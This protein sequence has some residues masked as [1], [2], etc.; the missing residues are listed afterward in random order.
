MGLSAGTKLG[1]YEII[2]RLGAGGMGEVFRAWDARLDR[3]VALKVIHPE[4]AADAD[5]LARFEQ[6]AKAA[7]RLD[8][9]NILV[10][11]DVGAHEG[12]PY[13]VSELLEGASLRERLGAPLSTK[14]A[15]DIALQIA[16]GLAAAHEK[17]I[18]HRDLKPE[19][20]FVLKDG[21]TKILDFGVAKLTQRTSDGAT[22]TEATTAAATEPG[23]V[24]GTIGYMSPEQVQGRPLE[25]RSDLFSLGVV[26]YEMLAGKRPF[27]GRTAP[28]TLTAILREEPPDLAEANQ[29]IPPPL[30]RIVR[31]CLEKDPARRFQAAR[32]LVFDLEALAGL[33]DARPPAP[34]SA[35]GVFLHRRRAAVAGAAFV[36]VLAVSGFLL[37][38]TR[39]AP[40][41]V[42]K[43]VAVLPFE[44]LTGDPEQAYLADGIHEAVITDLARLSGF[45]R[46]IARPSV[47][48]YRKIEQPLA[49]I[50]R[51]LGVDTLVTGSVLRAA[52]K[53]R[54]T[55][56]LIDATT[57][58]QVWSDSYEREPRDVLTLQN[59]IVRAIAAKAKLALTPA[60]KI[61]LAAARPVSPEAYE[62]YLKGRF[63]LNKMTPEGF[64][65]GI[66][67]LQQSIE[68][69]P[70]NPLPHAALALGYTLL[71]HDA[72][73]DV[74]D[75][76]KVAARR[77]SELGGS[78]AETEEAIAEIQEYSE[79]D[80]AAA[81]ASFQRAI[82]LNPSLPDA[83]AHYAWNLLL[84]GRYEQ[85]FAEAKRSVEVDP[86]TPIYSAW[87]GW[88][89]WQVG[90]NEEAI[91]AAKKSL[92]INTDFPWG[93]Y[94]LGSVH[95]Q[96]GQFEEAI[97]AHRRAVAASPALKWALGHTYAT[98]DRRPDALAVAAELEK[99]PAPMDVWGL[100][101]I[102]TAL[103]EKDAAFRWLEEGF[104]IRM[105][106]MPWIENE[107][108]FAPLRSDPRFG[109]LKRRIGVP[110]KKPAG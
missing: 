43:R 103:G 26:L 30:E 66:A 57:E 52:G 32:D 12:S 46:V 33:L 35:A 82:G 76:A 37:W 24:L 47:A 49:E 41:T 13:I 1:P 27:R 78:L 86:L 110:E 15:V 3:E 23:A 58:E 60:E 21:R 75:R 45:S 54:V 63:Q 92:E 22:D 56:H 74:F 88:M 104:R 77:A 100:A 9:P 84:R 25:S 48:A 18:V 68:K 16:R 31:H 10:V 64:K 106:W 72:M 79:W 51:K 109:D 91:A 83:H 90:R 71:G 40:G 5:R 19:N 97:A 20:V 85:A 81:E 59:E 53:L 98:A 55:A 50:G 99:S 87:L 2:S 107:I 65:K 36:A 42:G 70:A 89:Y 108:I 44:N 105:V 101:Q 38:R 69:D 62:A 80:F 34:M 4:F 67:Y 94:V 95:A 73:P 28:E 39:G 7:A 61:R 8:H 14:A 6:E 17:G 29:N 11:H 93:L 96:Q 102:Y